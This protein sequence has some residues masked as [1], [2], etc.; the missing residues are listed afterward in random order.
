MFDEN[1]N[2]EYIVDIS[3]T[4]EGTQQK[5][6]KDGYWYKEDYYSG[7]GIAEVLATAIC[8]AST[9]HL[10]DY[11]SYEYGYVNAKTACRSK[12]FLKPGEE[13]LSLYRVYNTLTGNNLAKDAAVLDTPKQR[14]EFVE[15][16]F[17][18]ECNIDLSKYF[19]K[20]FT[21]DYMILNE[22]RH[23][24][25]LGVILGADGKYREAPIFDNGK[26]LLIGNPSVNRN[27]SIAENL[28]RT[29]AKP[30]SGSFQKN[31]EL[32]GIG[33]QVDKKKLQLLLSQIPD[34]EEKKVLL[35]RL[36]DCQ[37][38]MYDKPIHKH[39]QEYDDYER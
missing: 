13:F 6:Y 24:N 28:Q 1:L 14:A 31:M 11:V 21:L 12:N 25:N 35:T 3:G 23:F 22:D 26:S 7:E 5:Y 32:Y 19:S 20:V 27:L 2:K 17:K 38:I 39:N 8:Q 29:T 34:F 15:N 16:F 37:F 18:T 10:K 4:S 36:Q 30:F 33:F 9:M